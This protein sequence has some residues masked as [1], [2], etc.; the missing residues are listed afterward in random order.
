M[1]D[2]LRQLLTCTQ[3]TDV[4]AQRIG[5]R[6]KRI[7]DAERACNAQQV[8]HADGPGIVGQ[9]ADRPLGHAGAVSDLPYGQT[10]QL[11]P[12]DEVLADLARSALNWKGS[13]RR[14]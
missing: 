14:H 11:A 3:P 8:L 2:A 10:A 4:G 13:R 6:H 7:E 9:T 12:R 1:P 5:G